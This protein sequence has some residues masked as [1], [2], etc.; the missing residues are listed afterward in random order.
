RRAALM[1]RP[2]F[3]PGRAVAPP[4]T[5]EA[6]RP[7]SPRRR[8]KKRPPPAPQGSR[9]RRRPGDCGM[10]ALL[11]RHRRGSLTPLGGVLGLQLRLLVGQLGEQLLVL[12]GLEV[13]EAVPFRRQLG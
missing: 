10:P 6:A 8:E 7:T 3:A 2:P 5:D 4:N 9:G 13:D 11:A 1:S 12:A